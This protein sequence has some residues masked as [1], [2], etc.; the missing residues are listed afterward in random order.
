LNIRNLK[1]VDFFPWALAYLEKNPRRIQVQQHRQ[2]TYFSDD[3]Q[4]IVA[5]KKQ[6]LEEKKAAESEAFQ[7]EFMYIAGDIL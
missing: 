2:K 5:E 6:Q 7:Q 1:S 4:A 3:I